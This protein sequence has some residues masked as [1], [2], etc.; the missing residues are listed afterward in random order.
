MLGEFEIGKEGWGDG[1]G[2]RYLKFLDFI[3]GFF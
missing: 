3:E 2:F 1:M